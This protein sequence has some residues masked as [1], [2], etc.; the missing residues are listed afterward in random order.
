[1]DLPSLAPLIEPV[2]VL[3]GIASVALVVR[4]HIGNWPVGIISSA[5]FLVLFAGAGLYADSA[6]QVMYIGL[7]CYGW[8]HWS[9]GGARGNDLPVTTA[10]PR[11]RAGLVLGAVLSAL[12]LGA[13]LDSAT[14]STV[15]YPD[16]ALMVLSITATHPAHA[17]AHRD[18]A[19]LD[20]RGQPPVHRHLP[21]Q[22]PR[23]D[24][25]PAA[26]LHR[27][28]GRGLGGL[29]ALDGGRSTGRSGPRPR[30]SG[31]GARSGGGRPMTTA[32]VLGKFLPPHAGH[33]YLAERARDLAD[34]VVVLVLANSAEP[35]PVSLRHRWLEE[36]LP[37]ATVCSGV[38][39]HPI[40]YA[41]PAVYDLWAAS[42]REV[43]GRPS[44]DLLLTSEPAYGQMTAERIGARHVLVDP[45]RAV[46][47]ISATA[48]RA[49]PYGTW[50]YL[51][52][53]VRAWYA[54][55][56][57]VTGA[58]STGTTT[59]TRAA[60]RLVRHG[61]G[62]G[63]RP[64]VQRSQ[65][66]SRRGLDHRRV[67]PHRAPPAGAGGRGRPLGEPDPV[68]RHGCAGDGDLA[69]AVPG[70]ACAGGGG[71]RSRSHVR[72]DPPDRR[73]HP[74]GAG[75]R[76]QLGRGPPAHAAAVRGGAGA[77]TGACRRAPRAAGASASRR[78]S[79]PSRPISGCVP[80]P[81]APPCTGGRRHDRRP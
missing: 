9:T 68:L 6:L 71:D 61:L 76:P 31:A 66:R 70:V 13:F 64:R 51:S 30:G 77:A 3:T 27:S 12:A 7:G 49:D 25:G 15:P 55:R 53:G 22:G 11:L 17:Q 18:L 59:T 16:A 46:V 62:A 24:G 34:E 79:R 44:F 19:S 43:T 57:C 47:P 8:W 69:R 74:L 54:K 81:R 45:D 28:L 4:Q 1:M 14:D 38:A 42:I 37:W 10:S 33:Q 73:R 35:I 58:E 72:P 52:P 23:D 39:D 21:V 63:V 36:M 29:A 26:G 20:L 32:L 56:V 80:R 50:D 60:G 2:A 67:R 78:P 41:D 5:L 75:R 40:D 65:G 48:V